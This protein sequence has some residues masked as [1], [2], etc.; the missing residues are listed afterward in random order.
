MVNDDAT[1]DEIL[2]GFLATDLEL[3]ACDLFG[4]Q[5]PAPGRCPSLDDVAKLDAYA[6]HVASIL[7]ARIARQTADTVPPPAR[8]AA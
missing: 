7:E 3:A 1:V 6:M 2:E 5:L 8:R 4:V